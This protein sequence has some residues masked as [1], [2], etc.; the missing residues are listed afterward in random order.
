MGELLFGTQRL[1]PKVSYTEEEW[2]SRS[3]PSL[4]P[5]CS[6]RGEL[7]KHDGSRKDKKW[8]V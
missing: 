8:R 3:N 5:L 2:E 4:C 1:I 6:G 7:R